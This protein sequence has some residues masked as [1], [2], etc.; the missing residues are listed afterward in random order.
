MLV[1]HIGSQACVGLWVQLSDLRDCGARLSCTHL[2]CGQWEVAT[3]ARRLCQVAR[4]ACLSRCLALLE[5][6][7]GMATGSPGGQCFHGHQA[8]GPKGHSRKPSGERVDGLV[9]LTPPLTPSLAPTWQVCK[10]H[11]SMCACSIQVRIRLARPN[12]VN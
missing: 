10:G 11:A 8:L 1:A 6:A 9:C 2:K 12:A 7:C 4:V 3:V 5:V